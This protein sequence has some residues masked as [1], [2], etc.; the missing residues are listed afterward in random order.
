MT[1]EYT[2]PTIMDYI[3]PKRW[4]KKNNIVI[5]DEYLN[6]LAINETVIF[7]IA[8]VVGACVAMIW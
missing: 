8:L 7:G 5:P 3:V 2:K 4:R 6:I 1:S